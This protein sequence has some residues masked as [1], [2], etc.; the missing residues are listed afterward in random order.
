MLHFTNHCLKSVKRLLGGVEK[1]ISANKLVEQMK[2]DLNLE[3]ILAKSAED[4]E[5]MLCKII[6][7]QEESASKKTATSSL[8]R[9]GGQEIIHLGNGALQLR[10]HIPHNQAQANRGFRNQSK[11]EDGSRSTGV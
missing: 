3:S 9:S 2:N 5:N 6:N 4:T 10:G 11:T 8:R 7:D 1:L